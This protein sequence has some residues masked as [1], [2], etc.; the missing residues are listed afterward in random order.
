MRGFLDSVTDT[1]YF[2][3]WAFDPARP[4]YALRVGIKADG[5][6][7]AEGRAH[8]FRRDLMEAEC[9]TGWCAFRLRQSDSARVVDKAVLTLVDVE[10]G[11]VLHENPYVAAISDPPIWDDSVAALCARDPTLI[12]EVWQLRGCNRHFNQFISEK[13]TD[14][15]VR[16]A[17][18][19]VLGRS[20]N[21]QE[22][23]QYE[24]QLRLATITPVGILEALSVCDKPQANRGSLAAPN[25]R[26]FPFA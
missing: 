23:A 25:A 11:A 8:R 7:I 16:T 10:T 9:G 26:A 20:A 1:G 19:Y 17:Y 13:G 4:L 18:L 22:L 5:Q 2:E 24:T 3:G 12:Q 6:W 15:F 14:C 21:E